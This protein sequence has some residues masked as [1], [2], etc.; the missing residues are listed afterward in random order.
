MRG[1][2]GR[3]AQRT[4]RRGLE[5]AHRFPPASV[6][7][8]GWGPARQ[9]ARPPFLPPGPPPAWLGSMA[10]PPSLRRRQPRRLRRRPGPAGGC[11]AAAAAA[12]ATHSRRRSSGS[13]GPAANV[14]HSQLLLQHRAQR[15]ERPGPCGSGRRTSRPAPAPAWSVQCPRALA[16]TA[17][18][19]SPFAAEVMYALT[20]IPGVGRRISNVVCK[21]AE[22]DMTKRA[23]ELTPDEIEKVVAIL[24]DPKKFNIPVWMVNRRRDKFDGKS[25][26]LVSNQIAS[27]LRD[28]L[29]HLKKVR[30]HRGLRHCEYIETA[31]GAAALRRGHTSM[32]SPAPRRASDPLLPPA[33]LRLNPQIGASRC[34]ASTPARRAA[35]ALPR[36][37]RRRSRRAASRPRARRSKRACE[38]ANS[39]LHP[40]QFFFQPPAHASASRSRASHQRPP[41]PH[42][43]PPQQRRQRWWVPVRAALALP[44]GAGWRPRCA[45]WRIAE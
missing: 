17:F 7:P 2:P 42:P 45:C 8:R 16:L 11:P 22:I 36:R 9:L 12:R 41:P 37:C 10:G 43:P 27:K 4:A 14:L 18:A 26:Q 29:E 34:A 30:T 24:Q 5:C 19:P 6:R 40:T 21:K 13:C 32:P 23:G 3:R 44:R 31:P 35:A 28:D 33:A 20:A 1:G 38:R 39:L 25:S 15:H